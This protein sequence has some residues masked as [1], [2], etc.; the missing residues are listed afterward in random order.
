MMNYIKSE[1]YRTIKGKGFYTA[2]AVLSGLV[3]FM[4]VVLAVSN[5]YIEGFRYGTFRFSLNMYT[6]SSFCMVLLGAVIPACLFW[7]DRRN[8]V[9]KNVISYGIAREK[10]FLGKCIVAFGF[11]ALILCAVLAV[12]IS[13]AYLLLENPEWEPLREMFMGVA[14]SLPSA[15]ASLVF[16]IFLG[17]VFQKEMTA[18]IVWATVYYLIPM[19]FFFAGL[20]VEV[21]AKILSWMP[22]GFLRTEAFVSMNSYYCLWDTAAGFAKCM[23]S[24]AAGIVIFLVVGIWKVRR[25]EL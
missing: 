10:M 3:L 6:G 11:T 12:Y 16:C 14:A 21:F 18:V 1:C 23:I 24:G 25:Q 19:G 9:M 2:I 8:G 5:R 15:M 22:Y 4:N 13:S 17:C 7:D 20:K